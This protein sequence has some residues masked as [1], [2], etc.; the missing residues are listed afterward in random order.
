MKQIDQVHKES[1]WVDVFTSSF[2]TGS[3]R[4]FFGP[5]RLKKLPAVSLVVGPEANLRITYLRN[6]RE[7]VLDMRPK[8]VV[9][10]L[11]QVIGNSD[12][13]GMEVFC[14]GHDH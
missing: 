7:E 11:S 13:R 14:H 4:R 10:D 6:G 8:C 2:F 5:A 12:V 9:P 1:C 3:I